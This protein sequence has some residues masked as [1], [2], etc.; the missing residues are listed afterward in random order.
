MLVAHGL[1]LLDLC[2]EK[3]PLGVEY[4]DVADHPVDILQ[5]GQHDILPGRLFEVELQ[6]CGPAHVAVGHY[7]VVD[8]PEDLQHLLLVGQPGLLVARQRRAV[9]CPL[10]TEGEERRR[11]VADGIGERRFDEPF[12]GVVLESARQRDRQSR[13]PVGIGHPGRGHC[14]FQVL[15]GLPHVGTAL[16]QRR[17]QPHGQRVGHLDVHIHFAARHAGGIASCEDRYLVLLLGD[18]QFEVGN[19][20]RGAC[21]LD[22]SLLV[23]RFGGQAAFETQPGLPHA[24]LAGLHRA[25][26]H[27]QLVI[28]GRQFEI[29]R[30]DFGDE[31]H[32][33]GPR[34]FDRGEVLRRSFS[35]GPPQAAP[36]VGLPAQGRLNAEFG[37]ALVCLAVIV[38]GLVVGENQS[39]ERRQT[40][41]FAHAV[42]LFQL[43][44]AR[45]GGLHVAV[46]VERAADQPAECRVG[47][48]FPPRQ[49]AD[50]QRIGASGNDL[51]RK[52]QFGGRAFF[53]HGA[54]SRRR[55]QQ[56]SENI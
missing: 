51:G 53:L 7:G 36:Q 33:Q 2:V 27:V 19:Q 16:Q 8:L 10:R 3:F 30:G 17:G 37:V 48:D 23:G 12:E 11:K 46:A 40:G 25:A 34:R 42:E 21:Q 52:V 49:V 31:R 15:L 54:T 50:G 45:L 55:Q 32:L 6:F 39:A 29:G 41:R 22:F 1:A 38:V 28:E 35:F 18:L 56:D 47:I 5:F 44:D 4:V 24:L 13:E 26:H 9:F 43:T 14:G 20:C